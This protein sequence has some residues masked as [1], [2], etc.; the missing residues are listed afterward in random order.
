ML[1]ELLDV[2]SISGME[3][4][5]DSVVLGLDPICGRA[6]G[7]SDLPERMGKGTPGTVSGSL[8]P[9]E[10]DQSLT[11]DDVVMVEDHVGQQRLSCGGGRYRQERVAPILALILSGTG[12]GR[13]VSKRQFEWAKEPYMQRE[14]THRTLC[15]RLCSIYRHHR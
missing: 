13:L 5:R 15:L 10:T 11:G 8:R 3:C 4:E 7:A 6:K 2:E 1:L 9:E 12:L 14:R